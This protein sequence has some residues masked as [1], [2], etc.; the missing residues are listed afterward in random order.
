M[1]SDQ[2]TNNILR[3]GK[4]TVCLSHK[5]KSSKCKANNSKTRINVSNPLFTN[6]ISKFWAY[7]TPVLNMIPAKVDRQQYPI[8]IL[9]WLKPARVVSDFDKSVCYDREYVTIFFIKFWAYVFLYIV[10]R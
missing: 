10:V 6:K 4:Q 7:F 1:D 5:N 2:N 3:H 8:L 9:F